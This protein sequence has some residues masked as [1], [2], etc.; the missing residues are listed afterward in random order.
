MNGENRTLSAALGGCSELSLFEAFAFRTPYPLTAT[1]ACR[2][3]G[4]PWATVH[5]RIRDWEFSGILSVVGKEGKAKKYSLN[6]ESPTINILSKA[7][8]SAV[9]ELF[10]SELV[11]H[12]ADMK[13]ETQQKKRVVHIVGE[14]EEMPWVSQGNV[15]VSSN[16]A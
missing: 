6:T 2:F 11:R 5:R 9:V 13:K 14:K 7:V 12:E 3:S 10:N 1:Q 16:L 4:V 15:N 8:K